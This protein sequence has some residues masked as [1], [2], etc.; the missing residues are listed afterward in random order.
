MRQTSTDKV[1]SP[2]S[3]RVT[4]AK[5]KKPTAPVHNDAT[6]NLFPNALIKFDLINNLS[7]KEDCVALVERL[8]RK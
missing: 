2:D 7:L 6:P 5:V 8:K 3:K 4:D 1:K